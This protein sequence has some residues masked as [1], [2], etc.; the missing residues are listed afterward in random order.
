MS[1]MEEGIL[2]VQLVHKPALETARVSMVWE[3]V[4]FTT[5]LKVSS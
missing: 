4:G 1:V 2:D 5:G 3:M